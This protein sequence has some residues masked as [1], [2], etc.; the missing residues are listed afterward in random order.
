[1]ELKNFVWLKNL[2]MSRMD[3]VK[4]ITFFTDKFSM[5]EDEVRVYFSGSKG[6]HIIVN[7]IVLGIQPHKQLH[8]IFKFVAN[9]LE[10]QL[11][12]QSLDTSSIY[13]HGRMLR[14]VNSIHF[15]SG[16]FKVELSYEELKG[17]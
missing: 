16:L 7:P 4:L 10:T 13:G 12:L 2:E 9:S 1:P 8:R 14:L 11:G 15:K 5:T 3:A 17:D 6:F